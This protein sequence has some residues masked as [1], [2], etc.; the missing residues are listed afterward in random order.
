MKK[1]KEPNFFKEMDSFIKPYKKRYI[2][3][4]MLSML[5]VLCELLSYAFVGILAG[6][7]FK[8]FH[9]NNMIYVL[10]FTI[11]CKISGV[12]L[13]NISTLISH[14][15][16]YLTLK[17]LRYAIC[18]KFVRL[19][20]GY[21]D[22]NPSGTLK[23]ILVD[24]VEDIEKTLA[25][26]LPEMTANLLIPIA[27]I[28]WMLAVNIKLTGII[29][30]WVIFGLSIGMLM[31]IGYKKKY[32][33]QVQAQKNMNQAVIEYVKG[34]E[35]IKT[36]NMEDSSYAKYKNA[37]IRHAEYA[38]NWMKSSQ[39]YASLSYSIA[40]V[41][42]FPTIVVGL[43]FFNNGFLTEQSLFLFMMIS[44]GIFK[45]I[46]KASSYVD[47][48]AQ[49]GT[50]TKEI[51]GILD[52]P[53]L[54]RSENS[55]LKEKMTYDI[56]F[57]NL[58]FSYDGTK[59][60]VDDVNLTIKEKTMTAIIGT[61]GSGKSTLMK[62][63]AGFWDFEKGKIK[64]GGIGVKDLSMNDLN[65]LISYVDQNTFLF[66]DTIL[67]NIRIGK[68]DATNDEVI[69]AAKRAGCH[70]FIV[71]LPDGYDTIAGDR[72]SGGEKQRIAIARAIL[73]NAPII[74]LDEA[75]A[76]TDIENE[77]KIQGALLEFTKGKTLIVIT[78]K[79]K[80]V[81]NADKIIY[82]ENGK[83]ICDGKHEELIKSCSTYKHL[84]EIAN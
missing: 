28:V 15:A 38:I 20:M 78:H 18:D 66:D 31:M 34:I 4:V 8:G 64:I 12:L 69:E 5:S 54:K 47:Q 13:S 17:D 29:F 3:S 80:T 11:I 67:E 65:T 82:M 16:A 71:T 75:T 45:P 14:K 61:S 35:V 59:N 84:Y 36:F 7:I 70:D 50:V 52:Y 40:P 62:L 79:I 48:L 53:E 43:I 23:T 10:I 46:V 68:K 37:V 41:S 33:G 44:L 19:P 83:I 30:L 73:K 58:Q 63:L 9:G 77:E 27:M 76:S 22:M 55:N 32:E 72:L 2:L 6:Y 26:L 49:M 56:A 42:I 39:I 57:E 74:I 1:E 24:R 25:H 51:K 60:D 21:F 81:I